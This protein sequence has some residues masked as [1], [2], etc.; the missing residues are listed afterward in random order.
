MDKWMY[1]S[2]CAYA[3]R[4]LETAMSDVGYAKCQVS[5]ARFF[6]Y[7]L[8]VIIII[9][10]VIF[11]IAGTSDSKYTAIIAIVVVAAGAYIY[12]EKFTKWKATN[13]YRKKTGYTPMN[14]GFNGQR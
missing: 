5:K 3:D 13:D 6:G 14:L 2:D 11:I 12:A 1:S 9:A 8:A 7:G 4:K 10:L